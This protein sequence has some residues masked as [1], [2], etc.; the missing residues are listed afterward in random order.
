MI[1]S[2]KV[3]KVII[4]I[5]IIIII[6]IHVKDRGIVEAVAVQSATTIPTTKTTTAWLWMA[7]VPAAAAAP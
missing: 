5:I 4:I 3:I 7:A 2:F 6:S 1:K